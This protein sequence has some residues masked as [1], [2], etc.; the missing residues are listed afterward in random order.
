MVRRRVNLGRNQR[1]RE[2]LSGNGAPSTRLAEELSAAVALEWAEEHPNRPPPIE[3][4]DLTEQELRKLTN[5]VARRIE[6]QADE[7]DKIIGALYRSPGY[8][9]EEEHEEMS[10]TLR[11]IAS[12]AKLSPRELEVY[13]LLLVEELDESDLPELLGVEPETVTKYKF[14]MMEKLRKAAKENGYSE[15]FKRIP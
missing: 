2:A 7:G 14:R 10:S 4:D 8:I 1:L 13:E 5:R 11:R 9:T 6:K 3:N 15:K 12:K